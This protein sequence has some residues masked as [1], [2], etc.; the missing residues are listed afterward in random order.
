MSQTPPDPAPVCYLVAARG[1]NRSH[2]VR[3]HCKPEPEGQDSLGIERVGRSSRKGGA[4]QQQHWQQHRMHWHELKTSV[5]LSIMLA[6]Q[7]L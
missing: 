2:D 5:A 6:M 3:C 4:L 1:I 7:D